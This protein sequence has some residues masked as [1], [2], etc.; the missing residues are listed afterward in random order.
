MSNALVIG[1]IEFAGRPVSR[2]V[3]LAGH[4]QRP[5]KHIP[6]EQTPDERLRRIAISMMR[7]LARQY[8]KEFA[9]VGR[10]L[11]SNGVK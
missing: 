10:E 9:D 5:V 6:R 7:E 3:P 1:K 4:G 8:P 2:D 11:I